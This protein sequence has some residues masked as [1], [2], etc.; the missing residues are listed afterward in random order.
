MELDINKLREND[1]KF[2]KNIL[3]NVYLKN[4]FQIQR[5]IQIILLQKKKI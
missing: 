1:L 5:Q 2:L 3:I 4:E